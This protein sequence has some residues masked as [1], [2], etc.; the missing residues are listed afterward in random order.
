MAAIGVMGTGWDRFPHIMWCVSAFL[1]Q[2]KAEK[3]CESRV[4]VPVSQ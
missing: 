4:K 1:P 3:V 2:A